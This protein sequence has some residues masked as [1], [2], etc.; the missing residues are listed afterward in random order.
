MAAAFL[1]KTARSAMPV[2]AEATAAMTQPL[3]DG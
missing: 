1:A 3:T 2:T